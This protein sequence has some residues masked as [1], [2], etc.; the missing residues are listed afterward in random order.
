MNLYAEAG[1][2]NSCLSLWERA[3]VRETPAAVDV[4]SHPMKTCIF[5]G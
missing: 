5:P 4:R 3:G 2:C 1:T